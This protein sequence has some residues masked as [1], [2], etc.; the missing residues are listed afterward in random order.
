[1]TIYS[2]GKEHLVLCLWNI[3]HMQLNTVAE[4]TDAVHFNFN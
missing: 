4:V 2:F 3:G 1:M